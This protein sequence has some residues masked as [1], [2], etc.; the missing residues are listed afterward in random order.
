MVHFGL[1]AWLSE[2]GNAAS[3]GVILRLVASISDIFSLA[4]SAGFKT[5]RT[6]TAT[7]PIR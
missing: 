2:E 6:I 7:P 4:L 5:A 3:R 1:L